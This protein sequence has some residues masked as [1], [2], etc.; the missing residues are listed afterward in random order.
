MP[1]NW[2]VD[3]VLDTDEI[4][5]T[6][7]PGAKAACTTFTS[8]PTGAS[9]VTANE[10]M[11]KRI[12]PQVLLTTTLDPTNF[13]TAIAA[14]VNF[15]VNPTTTGTQVGAGIESAIKNALIPVL[16]AGIPMLTMT[17]PKISGVTAITTRGSPSNPVPPLLGPNES[18]HQFIEELPK[19]SG[20][21]P[22]VG[23]WNESILQIEVK[24]RYD[25][26]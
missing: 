19:T 13:G 12:N 20:K 17:K 10:L 8:T 1:H 11:Q 26:A 3:K 2:Q 5:T 18:I 6:R 7:F 16:Q 25:A 9:S 15:A 22:C 21:L 24:E 23:T 4:A 14:A